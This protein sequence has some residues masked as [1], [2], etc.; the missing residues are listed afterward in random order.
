[1][2]FAAVPLFVIGA[3]DLL[4]AAAAAAG[5]VFAWREGTRKQKARWAEKPAAS[6][7]GSSNGCPPHA[8]FKGK[9]M[10]FLAEALGITREELR[11]NIHSLKEKLENN[12]DVAICR[13][14]GDVAAP[15]SGDIIG[16]LKG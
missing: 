10:K 11:A 16:N 2:A 7:Q 4:L 14:C 5:A 6:S 13:K 12:P 1:M 3:E 8:W 15:E 9:D